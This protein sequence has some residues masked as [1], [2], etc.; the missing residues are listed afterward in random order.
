MLLER[1]RELR[2]ISISASFG[3]QGEAQRGGSEHL[4]R[5]S[6]SGSDDLLVRR[7]AD[8]R[9]KR[10]LKRAPGWRCC[11][12]AADLKDWA[13]DS[14]IVLTRRPARSPGLR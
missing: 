4:A 3:D 1:R 5:V 8:V 14:T 10:K 6:K 11:V 12:G 9:S 13:F 7:S 2:G